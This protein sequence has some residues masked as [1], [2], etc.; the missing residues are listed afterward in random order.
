MREIEIKLEREANAGKRRKR[1]I[2]I[3]TKRE[4]T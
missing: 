1:E 3:E 4:T 2:G